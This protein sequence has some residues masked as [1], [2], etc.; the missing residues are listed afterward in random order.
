MN[1]VG[2][3]HTTQQAGDN[4]ACQAKSATTATPH[5]LDSSAC[6]QS[7]IRCDQRASTPRALLSTEHSMEDCAVACG[8]RIAQEIG[9]PVIAMQ[10]SSAT[11]TKQGRPAEAPR[12]N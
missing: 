2:Y 11:T 10:Q 9:V 5:Q 12:L 8:M 6:L 3:N 1:G 7:F 4:V